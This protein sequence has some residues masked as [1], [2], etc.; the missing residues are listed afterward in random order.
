VSLNVRQRLQLPMRSIA[1]ASFSPAPRPERSL[2]QMKAMR[3]AVFTPTPGGSAAI[4]E[5][6]QEGGG[7]HGQG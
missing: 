4:D 1:A 2:E 3:C 7:G 5:F 6:V